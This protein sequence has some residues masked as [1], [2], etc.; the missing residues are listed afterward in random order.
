MANTPSSKSK[1]TVDIP[2]EL[3]RALRRAQINAE[4]KGIPFP[5]NLSAAFAEALLFYLQAKAPEALEPQ[6]PGRPRVSA[7]KAPARKP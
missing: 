7:R 6:G 4:E 3:I 1:K 5:P 2:P